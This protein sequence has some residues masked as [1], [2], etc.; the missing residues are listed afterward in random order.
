M[1][2]LKRKFSKIFM[3]KL[4]YKH[5]FIQFDAFIDEMVHLFFSKSGCLDAKVLKTV[6]DILR[7]IFVYF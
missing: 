5:Q 3:I 1:T 7:I 2:T 4:S 6:R